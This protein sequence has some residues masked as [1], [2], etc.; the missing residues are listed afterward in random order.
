MSYDAVRDW[1]NSNGISSVNEI[2]AAIRTYPSLMN[3]VDIESLVPLNADEFKANFFEALT[4]AKQ[5]QDDLELQLQM[6]RLR[7][8]MEKEVE[9]ERLRLEKEKKKE[10][11][12]EVER[13]RSTAFSCL[14]SLSIDGDLR[15]KAEFAIHRNME[16]VINILCTSSSESMIRSLLERA[17]ATPHQ[18]SALPQASTYEYA[19]DIPLKLAG[20]VPSVSPSTQKVDAGVTPGAKHGALRCGPGHSGHYHAMG[21]ATIMTSAYEQIQE[22]DT[23]TDFDGWGDLTKYI[24]MERFS[25]HLRALAK[26]VHTLLNSSTSRHELEWT[27]YYNQAWNCFAARVLSKPASVS[28]LE[29]GKLQRAVIQVHQL[30]IGKGRTCDAGAA[31]AHGG[32]DALDM[33]SNP[34]RLCKMK[35]DKSFDDMLSGNTHFQVQN[36]LQTLRGSVAARCKRDILQPFLSEVISSKGMLLQL[37]LPC[38]VGSQLGEFYP[39]AK[40]KDSMFVP[41]TLVAIEK[42]SLEQLMAIFAGMLCTQLALGEQL[43]FGREGVVRA[44]AFVLPDLRVEGT[45]LQRPSGYFDNLLFYNVAAR[46]APSQKLLIKLFDYSHRAEGV[47]YNCRPIAPVE[48]SQRRRPPNAVLLDLINT[49]Q[50]EEYLVE[51]KRASKECAIM[52]YGFIPGIHSPQ[53]W[54]QMRSVLSLLSKAHENG[55]VHG[56]I[57]PQNL[58][59]GPSLSTIIDWDLWRYEHRKPAYIK[60]FNIHPFEAIRHPASGEERPMKRAHDCYS[61]AQLIQLWFEEEA[62]VADDGNWLDNL[63]T[64]EY[65]SSNLL[66]RAPAHARLKSNLVA[67]ITQTTKSPLRN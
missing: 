41:V 1:L 65:L 29:W 10:E 32:S 52:I 57:L 21:F 39:P 23:V 30:H 66:A 43:V 2:I 11:K 54:D 20:Q 17:L 19:T 6:G 25:Q 42:P 7:L 5:R 37:M 15:S 36:Q 18:A 26:Q 45:G 4:A 59:F 46:G 44:P 58:I 48:E 24:T 63:K 67:P 13:R 51:V 3:H 47:W 53:S 33:F 62:F 27:G 8:E 34:V 12:Q 49:H 22:H 28:E 31:V 16:V 9:V 40:G 56:D 55:I 61:M 64:A 60:G 14:G 38:L 35:K 50:G